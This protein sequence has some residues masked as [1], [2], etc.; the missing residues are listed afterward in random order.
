MTL[1][2]LDS[3]NNPIPALRLKN[4]GAHSIAATTSTA[5]NST[6]FNGSTEIVSIYTDV[7]VYIKMGDVTVTANSSDHYFPE[8]I[9]YD[10]AIGAD[11]ANHNTHIAVLRAGAE[12]GTVYISEKE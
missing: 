4:G 8:G 7:P 3:N 11:N 12:D 5:R 2:P 10:F 6:A 1:Q 9:Y